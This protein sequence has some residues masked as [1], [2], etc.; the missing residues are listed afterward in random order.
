ML[1]YNWRAIG[2]S[3]S[4]EAQFWEGEAVVSKWPSNYFKCPTIPKVLFLPLEEEEE[5]QEQEEILEMIFTVPN[6]RL[7]GF[8]QLSVSLVQLISGSQVADERVPANTFTWWF[9]LLGTRK[10]T[11]WVSIGCK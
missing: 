9:S 11:K 3:E 4:S 10:Y 2:Q 8:S 7:G 6:N 1:A 5:E